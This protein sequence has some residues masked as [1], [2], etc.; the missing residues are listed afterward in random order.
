[1]TV[2]FLGDVKI[3]SNEYNK[4]KTIFNRLNER[5]IGYNI[6]KIGTISIHINEK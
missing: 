2:K 6:G 1:M 3:R 5:Q 4:N